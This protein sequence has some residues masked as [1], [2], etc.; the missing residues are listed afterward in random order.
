[1]SPSFETTRCAVC[2]YEGRVYKRPRIIE[3][4]PQ[5]GYV[6]KADAGYIYQH[7][8]MVRE[9]GDWGSPHLTVCDQPD[10]RFATAP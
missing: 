9:P 10:P 2:G 3:L 6:V 7:L 5:H 1:M 8:P 4:S